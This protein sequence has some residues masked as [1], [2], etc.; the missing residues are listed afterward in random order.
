MNNPGAILVGKG[1]GVPEWAKAFGAELGQS[2]SVGTLLKF[3]D[4]ESGR[5]AQ[6]ALWDRSYSNLTLG[7]ATAKWVHGNPNAAP[8]TDYLATLTSGGVAKKPQDKAPGAPGEGAGAVRVADSAPGVQASNARM[9]AADREDMVQ[10]AQLTAA[11]NA[12]AMTNPME[13]MLAG[14]AAAMKADEEK[15]PDPNKPNTFV[16]PEYDAMGNVTIPGFAV[17]GGGRG[18]GAAEVAARKAAATP[19]P[20]KVVKPKPQ[21]KTI[22]VDDPNWDRHAKSRAMF[23]AHQDA[24]RRGDSGTS[25]MFFAA[26]KQRQLELGM[27]P[28]KIKKTI[29]VAP[30]AEKAVPLPPPRPNEKLLQTG[31]GDEYGFQGEQGDILQRALEEGK[32]RDNVE[33]IQQPMQSMYDKQQA[34]MRVGMFDADEESA[35]GEQAKKEQA[36]IEQDS[37]VASK[38]AAG[39]SL[40]EQQ[41]QGSPAGMTLRNAALANNYDVE[42][43]REEAARASAREGDDRDQGAAYKATDPSKTETT[44]PDADGGWLKKYFPYI[45]DSNGSGMPMGGF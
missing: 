17:T 24:E 29:T 18:D 2:N 25:A 37:A 33:K 26:D 39:Q 27:K 15:K 43:K 11:A 9:D 23:Q 34:A 3:P 30:K 28:P 31:L 35:H 6:K 12:K 7:Q 42:G 36:L 44:N 4:M 16:G 20:E 41:R 45:F 19:P 8:P 13:K 14:Q 10:G 1:K 38:G 21:T 5:K 22:E 40:V 32:A